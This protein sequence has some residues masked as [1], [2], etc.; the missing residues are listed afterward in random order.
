M[1][2]FKAVFDGPH[3]HELLSVVPP[4]HHEGVDQALHDGALGLAEPLG[5]VTAG[6]VRDVLGVLVLDSDVVLEGTI[7]ESW[8]LENIL[9]PKQRYFLKLSQ[10]FLCFS[11]QCSLQMVSEIL[12]VFAESSR[13]L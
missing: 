5:G 6:A 7:T 11:K 4:V 1:D 12:V 8:F 3:G 2:D 10:R 9:K 13:K